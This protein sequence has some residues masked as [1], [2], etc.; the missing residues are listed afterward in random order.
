MEPGDK[1]ENFMLE[2]I[3]LAAE[4]LGQEFQVT[5]NNQGGFEEK[6]PQED[7][8]ILREKVNFLLLCGMR[9]CVLKKSFGFLKT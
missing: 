5:S 9:T 8:K 4:L 2:P 6:L 7:S 1:P 3:L